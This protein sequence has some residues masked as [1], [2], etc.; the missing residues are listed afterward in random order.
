M[1]VGGL[2]V[3]YVLLTRTILALP[4]SGEKDKC[5]AARRM[6]M[7]TTKKILLVLSGLIPLLGLVGKPPDPQL[8]I[9]TAFVVVVLL[10]RQFEAL[11][12]RL[13]G[14]AALHLVVMFVL[15]GSFAEI[16]AW[17]NS[18]F[19]A[20][21]HPALLHPQLIPDLILGFGLYGGWAVA[22]LIAFRWFQFNL[23]EVFLATGFL[24]I[25]L[26]QLGAVFQA[27]MRA[28]TVNP[29]QS[30]AMGAY[31]LTVYGSVAGLALAPL[32]NRLDSPEK[33]RSWVRFPVVIALLVVLGVSGIYLMGLCALAMDGLPPKRSIIEHPLW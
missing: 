3:K 28:L 11:V 25:V 1:R 23:L 32:V 15:S 16:L 31:L 20:A 12:G 13:P 7:G 19:R 17:M 18:Y 14:S 10:R 29:L 24:G 21:E 30:L 27:M 2:F 4:G 33:H 9:Y 5:K 22:W 6:R 26:E 8:C